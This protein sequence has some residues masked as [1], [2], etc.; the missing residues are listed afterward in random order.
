[1]KISLKNVSKKFKESTALENIDFS[2]EDGELVSILGPSGCGKSTLLSIISGLEM[3]TSGF[4]Y[5]DDIEVN[6]ISPENRDIGMVF[7]DYALYPHMTARENI[8]FPLKMK[9]VKKQEMVGMVNNVSSLL[10]I[11]SLLNKKPSKLSGGQQQRVAIARALVK[12]PKLLLLDE[13]LSNLDA[14]LRIKLREDIRELQK[15]LNITTIFVTHDQEEAMSISD[16][17]LLMNNGNI[18]QYGSPEEIYFHP[19]SA[20]AGKFLGTPEMNILNGFLDEDSLRITGLNTALPL[21]STKSFMDNTLDEGSLRSTGLNTTLPLNSTESFLDNTLSDSNI[22]VLFGIRPEDFEISQSGPIEGVVEN[23]QIL[24]K[25]IYINVLSDSIRFKI[26][27][28]YSGKYRKGDLIKVEPLK[29]HC[30]PY[31]K[32]I[33][34]NKGD[35]NE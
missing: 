33:L 13:P 2:I 18:I 31:D 22:P 21:N 7:Q 17:I 29:I 5:F 23:I 3:P 11:T 12:K 15:K 1:M 16:R 28:P 6:D 14:R 8:M 10:N 9:G 25:E 19:K 27:Q 35:F 30:F 26:V 20:F 32:S 34:D 4:V 24:G